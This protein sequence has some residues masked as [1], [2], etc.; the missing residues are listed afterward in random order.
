MSAAEQK[1]KTAADLLRDKSA[2]ELND[3]LMNLLKEQ[4]NLRMQSSTGQL[5][6]THHF[7]RVRKEIARIKTILAEQ[8][9]KAN[10]SNTNKA[11][12]GS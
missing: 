5:P 4:F 11:E 2:S 12:V 6:Q 9:K 8:A 10:E 7:K 1:E 3:E